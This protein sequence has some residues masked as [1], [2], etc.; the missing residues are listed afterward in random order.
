MPSYTCAAPP[1][2]CR[3]REFFDSLGVGNEMLDE[4]TSHD[5]R[6]SLG[7]GG[8]RGPAPRIGLAAAIRRHPRWVIAPVLLLVGTAIAIGLARPATYTSEA[9]LTV[10]RI[11]VANAGAL[12][13]FSEASQALAD[14]YSRSIDADG[15][16][17][18]TARETGLSPSLVR[19]RITATPVPRS[20]V[21]RITAT[22][23]STEDAT[24]LANATSNAL[25]AYVT[26]LNR[27]NP[28]AER[29]AKSYRR[30]SLE[31]ARR[32]SLENLLR[33]GDK[34]AYQRARA[35]TNLTQLRV[36][37]LRSVYLT[38]QQGQA[39]TALVQVLSQANEA[40]SDRSSRLQLL[41]FFALLAGLVVGCA[42][43][44]LRANQAARRVA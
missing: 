24:T 32:Q 43:A 37:T 9:R 29:L 33:D 21:F 14:A 4:I 35:E 5:T 28:D 20:P 11:N 3:L 34:G 22:G 23:P 10:G 16:V 36:E 25:V 19:Q 44:L 1:D 7:N 12:A 13:G 27:S 17:V 18:A 8:A 2:F 6:S 40:I 30:A 31:L 26:K 38:S 39:S 41:V 15:V 42:L